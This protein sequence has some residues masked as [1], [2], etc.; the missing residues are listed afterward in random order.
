MVE[1]F[2]DK[3]VNDIVDSLDCILFVGDR[4]KD[5]KQER[6]KLRKM[7]KRWCNELDRKDRIDEEYEE[8]TTLGINANY[9]S[10]NEIKIQNNSINNGGSTDYYKFKENWK[11]CQDIIEDREL[12]FSQGNIFKSAFCFNIGRHSAT[13]YERELNK[14]I[15]FANRELERIKREIL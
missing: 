10:S 7:I 8:N 6:D 2:N 9:I 12:N 1:I 4:L 13:D 5:D 14:I 15:Y 11:E 3:K